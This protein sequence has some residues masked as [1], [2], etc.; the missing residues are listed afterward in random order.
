MF[1]LAAAAVDENGHGASEAAARKAACSSASTNSTVSVTRGEPSGPALK[2]ATTTEA[3]G[4]GVETV[5][6]EAP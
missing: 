1:R 2:V 6:E 5:V 3:P 4:A